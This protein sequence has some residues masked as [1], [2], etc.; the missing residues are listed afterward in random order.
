MNADFRSLNA[1]RRQRGSPELARPLSRDLSTSGWSLYDLASSR[2]CGRRRRD[3]CGLAERRGDVAHKHEHDWRAGR[4][5]CVR[6]PTREDG[7]RAH[8]TSAR[9][10][11]RDARR[12]APAFPSSFSRRRDPACCCRPTPPARPALASAS[13]PPRGARVRRACCSR[14]WQRSPTAGAKWLFVARE[15]RGGGERARSVSATT[16]TGR[17]DTSPARAARASRDRRNRF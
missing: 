5:A 10:T 12:A 7:P 16:H 14:S 17:H 1:R 9:P 11:T 13:S 8:A 4:R 15:R 3:F 2:S 6:A